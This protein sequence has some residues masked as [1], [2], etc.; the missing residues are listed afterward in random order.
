MNTIDQLMALDPLDLTKDP[1]ALEAVIK[2]IRDLGRQY[3]AG[4]KPKKGEMPELTLE[5]ISLAPPKP[6]LTRRKLT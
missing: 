4:I 2:Y 5:S 3:E 1:K 6:A